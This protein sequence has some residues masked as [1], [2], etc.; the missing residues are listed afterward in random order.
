MA[1][2]TGGVRRAGKCLGLCS[3]R[4]NRAG[5]DRFAMIAAA[6]MAL[7]CLPEGVARAQSSPPNPAPAPDGP[8]N[9]FY[10]AVPPEGA[11]GPVLVFVHGLKGIAAD[12]WVN[13]INGSPN[14]SKSDGYT[15]AAAAL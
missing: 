12:W 5:F 13:A 6:V 14:P 10:G 9:I 1:L 7:L 11:K 15:N 4:S 2:L 8:A 3:K